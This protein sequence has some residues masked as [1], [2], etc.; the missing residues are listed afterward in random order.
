MDHVIEALKQDAIS[1]LQALAVPAPF[2][3]LVGFYA[4][5]RQLW[6]DMARATRQGATNILMLM[7]DTILV[8]PIVVLVIAVLGYVIKTNGLQIVPPAIWDNLP[9]FV[10]AFAAVFLGDFIGY[11]R[12]RMEHLPLFWPS[13]AVH[14]SDDEMTWLAVFRFHPFNRLTTVTIDFAWL[15]AMG[16]PEYAVMSQLLVRSYYG[17]F[18]HADLPWT[19]GWWGKIFVSPAMHRWHHARDVQAYNTNFATVFSLFDRALGT[20]RVPGPCDVPLGVPDKI[21]D[22]FVDQLTYP[23]KPRAYRHLARLVRGWRDRHRAAVA[24]KQTP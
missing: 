24:A 4:K 7:T 6:R 3:I 20:F 8:M 22:G 21:G 15:F 17:A 9:P 18:I 1:V 13:H 14:H 5:G 12:H 16:L 19:Y 11:W 2:F 10:V 23:V